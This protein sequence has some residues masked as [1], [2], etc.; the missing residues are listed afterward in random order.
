MPPI[1]HHYDIFMPL[2]SHLYIIVII[3]RRRWMLLPVSG[4]LD[5]DDVAVDLVAP[6]VAVLHLVAATV[7]GD[8]GPRITGKLAL[9]ALK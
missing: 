6:V 9:V 5:C 1:R 3:T 4:V 7:Q 2:I 8:A